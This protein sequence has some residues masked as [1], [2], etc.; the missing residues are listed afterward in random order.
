MSCS[1]N[2]AFQVYESCTQGVILFLLKFLVFIIR[3]CLLSVVKAGSFFS[4][5]DQMK[6]LSKVHHAIAPFWQD[7]SCSSLDFMFM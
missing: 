1:E 4:P 3:A 2:V 6:Y 5:G 7:G